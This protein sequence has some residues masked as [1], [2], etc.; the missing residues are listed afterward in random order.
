MF[1]R[2]TRGASDPT[3]YDDMV[4]ITEDFA[5]TFKRM[6]GFVSY[7]G[8]ANRTTGAF[9]SITTWETAETANFSR[10]SL[11]EVFQ[12]LLA[13]GARLDPAEVYEV[14]RTA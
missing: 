13:L 9:V 11:G 12:R 2:V 7:Q 5:A 6:P 3:R 14:V 1:V 4:A 10:D 8:A